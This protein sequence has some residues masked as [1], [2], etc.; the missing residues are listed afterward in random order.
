[1]STV[2]NKANFKVRAK[3]TGNEVTLFKTTTFCKHLPPSIHTH[4]HKRT[5]MITTLS[6]LYMNFTDTKSMCNGNT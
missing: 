4:T 2:H 6:N 5:H 1:M 3:K